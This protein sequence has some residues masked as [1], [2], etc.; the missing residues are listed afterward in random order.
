M[1]KATKEHFANFDVSY[2]SDN[3]KSCKIVKLFFSNKL[4]AITTIKLI[5]KNKIIDDEIKTAKLFNK[6]FVKID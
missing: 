2:M 6:Y 1:K 3:K 5:E 4:K